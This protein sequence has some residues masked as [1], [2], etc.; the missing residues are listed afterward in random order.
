[1]QAQ[2][3]EITKGYDQKVNATHG[4]SI[5]VPTW[6]MQL[7]LQEVAQVSLYRQRV[8]LADLELQALENQ[9]RANDQ[10]EQADEIFR[11]RQ[12][13]EKNHWSKEQVQKQ[14]IAQRALQRT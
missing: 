7:F 6:H 14:V 9:F 8:A 1:M 3:K 13:I 11:I 4:G 12:R 2:L 10:P 5:N